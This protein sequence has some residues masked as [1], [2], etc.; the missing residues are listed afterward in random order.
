M[1]LNMKTTTTID[2]VRRWLKR[3]GNTPASLA[4]RLGY[5]SSST[6][7]KWLQKGKVPRCREKQVTEAL[8]GSDE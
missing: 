2:R 5:A 6:V 1:L 8:G 3:P 4:V 7:E